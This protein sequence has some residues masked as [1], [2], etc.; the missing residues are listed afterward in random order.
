M[1][2]ISI[3][4][5]AIVVISLSATHISHAVTDVAPT[6]DTAASLRDDTAAARTHRY[7][8]WHAKHRDAFRRIQ[9]A[10]S[11]T[12]ALIDVRALHV[13]DSDIDVPPVV[14][15][16]RDTGAVLW[17]C[18]LCPQMTI[19][20]AGVFT[21]GSPPDE[22]GR[23]KDESPQRRI[24]ILR[25]FA[26]SRFE[27][28]RGEYAAFLRATGHPVSKEC[29]TDRVHHGTWA[30]ESNTTLNDP[31]FPQTDRHPVVCVTW[32]DAQ[33]YIAWLNARTGGRYRLLTESEWEYVARAGATAA[34]PWG[35][36]ADD[37]CTQANG[38][39]A[40]FAEHYANAAVA[41][42]RDGALNTAPVG[43][44]RANAFGLYDMIGN[45]EEWVA[46][47][48]TM[49]YASLP[50]DGSADLSGDCARHPVRGGSWGSE[51]KDARV[52]NR[53]RYPASQ[54]DDSVGIRV[55]KTL[56]IDPPQHHFNSND[57]NIHVSEQEVRSPPSVR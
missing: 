16:T 26:V 7:Q 9:R 38:T 41:K 4:Q 52:A 14:F 36:S 57:D 50:A 23:G 10:V 25:P 30:P 21:I 5:C 35:A 48:A 3:L 34:F 17:D 56:V 51:V 53:V 40:V 49:A 1:R 20:P 31:G 12:R 37:G 6:G 43:A 39:D 24:A 45:A 8:R 42:C 54:V 33:A 18:A 44:Y 13:S 28:M 22:P 46:D 19:V 11:E 2:L 27:I 32:D 29:V 47:C 15:R 55:A